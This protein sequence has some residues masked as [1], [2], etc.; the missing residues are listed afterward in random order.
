MTI[1]IVDEWP[2]D[3]L[4]TGDTTLVRSLSNMVMLVVRQPGKLYAHYITLEGGCYAL[5]HTLGTEDRIFERLY[6]R[7]AP[8]ALSQL[9]IDNEFL[10]DLPDA[11]GRATSTTEQIPRA[12]ERL[13]AL[14][15]LPAAFPIEEILDST[16]PRAREAAVRHRRPE[17]RQRQPPAQRSRD[18]STG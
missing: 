3:V 16:R 1:A 9:V 15:L 13:D 6:E 14:D 11:L 12:G 7:L 10:P 17:L 4:K 5:E 18:P 2:A 8:L